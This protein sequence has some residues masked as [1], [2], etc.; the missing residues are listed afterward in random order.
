MLDPQELRSREQSRA[1]GGGCSCPLPEE[2]GAPPNETSLG[3][4]HVP[5]TGIWIPSL[6]TLA[7]EAKHTFASGRASAGAG[8]GAGPREPALSAPGAGDR[9]TS[10]S[11]P[12]RAHSGRHWGA[13]LQVPMPKTPACT[14]FSSTEAVL[15][16]FT[17]PLRPASPQLC[18][19]GWGGDFLSLGL[20]FPLCKMGSQP[21]L[22]SGPP[23]DPAGP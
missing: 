19:S 10:L 13:N 22:L 20:C 5:G 23:Q 6:S 16:A 14:P 4:A 1:G 17:S 2:L 9:A 15:A 8:G 11:S 18:D 12:S 7:F 3:Q 21:Y